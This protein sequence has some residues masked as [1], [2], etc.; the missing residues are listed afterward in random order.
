MNNRHRTI[1]KISKHQKCPCCRAVLYSRS[2]SEDHCGCVETIERCD[3]CGYL[4]HYSYGNTE[5]G[6]GRKSYYFS[7]TTNPEKIEKIF[8][9]FGSDIKRFRRNGFK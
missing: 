8:D 2:W 4:N 3:E 1:N 7:Y 9:K 6:I 5:L